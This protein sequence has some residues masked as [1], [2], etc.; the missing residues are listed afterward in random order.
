MSNS[1]IF[2]VN[3]IRYLMDYQQWSGVGTLE[4]IQTQTA[5]GITDSDGY[6]DFTN[7]SSDV[8]N[9]HFFTWSVD[10]S[11]SAPLYLRFRES[12][13]WE[14]S[15]VYD[16]ANKY[17]DTGGSDGDEKDSSATYIQLTTSFAGGITSGFVYFYNLGDA[18]KYSFTTHQAIKDEHYRYG[19]GLMHQTSF[20][21]GIR[22]GKTGSTSYDIIHSSLYGIRYS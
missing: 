5:T 12:G 22:F 8:Y 19:S 18:E 1:G 17:G 3:D 15:S 10:T 9:V 14:T 7:I 2:D 16:Y 20:V 13:T 11:N 6:I 4:L 21:D